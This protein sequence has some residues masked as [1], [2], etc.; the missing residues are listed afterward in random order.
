MQTTHDKKESK[1]NSFQMTIS[2]E[3]SQIDDW[4]NGFYF[5]DLRIPD[6]IELNRHIIKKSAYILDYP[7]NNIAR[8]TTKRPQIQI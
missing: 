2:M 4:L 3:T 1:F 8:P 5:I 6:K 7:I